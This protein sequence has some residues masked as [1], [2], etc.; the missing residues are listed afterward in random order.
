MD[1]IF[2]DKTGTLTCNKMFFKYCVIGV[3]CYE[4]KNDKNLN[5]NKIV[6][7]ML[8]INVRPK[9]EIEIIGKDYFNFLFKGKQ[10]QFDK[11]FETIRIISNG[12]EL[13]Q[14]KNEENLIKE[15]W[16]LITT[17]HECIIDETENGKMEFSVFYK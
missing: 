2:S 3:K 7:K 5:Q 17:C 15:Y 12:R 1:F 11:P 10:G 14:I 13:Y 4:Y 9:D 16:K 8:S 6:S